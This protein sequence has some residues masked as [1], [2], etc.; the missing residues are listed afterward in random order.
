MKYKC[1]VCGFIYDEA[2]EGKAWENLGE[3]W[4]CPI[5]GVGKDMFLRE[6]EGRI[7]GIRAKPQLT[8]ESARRTASDLIAETLCNF[9]VRRVFGM[10]GHSNL[11]MADAIR[12]LAERGR[13]EFTSIRHEGAAAFAAAAYGKLTGVPAACLT[14]AGPGA[15][16]LLTGLADAAL[17]RAPVIALTGQVP[18]RELGRNAFQEIDLV[19]ALG[20][21]ASSQQTASATSDFAAMAAR[22]CRHAITTRAVAQIVLPDDVQTTPVAPDV[23]AGTPDGAVFNAM[24]VRASDVAADDAVALLS[25]AK[26]PFVIVGEGCRHAIKEALEFAEILHASVATTYRAKGFVPDAFPAACGVVGRS[27]TPV[28]AKMMAESDC[29]VGLGV[30]FSNHSE[31][32]KGKPTV[33][34]DRDSSALGRLRKVDCGVLGELSETLPELSRRLRGNVAAE[35]PRERIAELWA[36]WRT[37]KS[38]RAEHGAFGKI[39]PAAV[40]AALSECVPEN[41]IVSVD[42]GNVAYSFG[43]Y[44]EA[45]NQRVLLSFYLGSIG[46]GL[47]AAIGAWC[48]TQDNAALAQRPVVAV[49][50]DGGLAQYLAEWTTV[51][52]CGMDVKCV[53]FNNSELAKISLEQRNARV[54]VWETRLHNPNFAE[55]AKLCGSAGVRIE[56]PEK[57]HEELA[58]AFSIPGPVLIEVLTDPEAS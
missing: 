21:A 6:E 1:G 16:N 36:E 48:A 11:G 58:R 37:E 52:R 14:I 29:I 45:K 22:A 23:P 32:A 24:P 53:V 19:R 25:R 26:R 33:Q 40:C 3:D 5:C 13:M 9:G 39:A 38:R 17:D 34:I 55:F 30:S 51:V 49:V 42:V 46:V 2:K 56:N 47:P 50:G 44:F 7:S 31:I 41:A 12:S 57:L 8:L 10:V 28:S 15:T 18:S 4:V 20:V 43:R 35:D 54:D 27:G